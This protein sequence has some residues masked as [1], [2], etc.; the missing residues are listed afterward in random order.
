MLT[1]K[2]VYIYI[3]IYIYVLHVHQISYFVAK[4]SKPI[5]DMVTVGQLKTMS[6]PEVSNDTKDV[7][8]PITSSF[9]KTLGG[10]GDNSIVVVAN[11]TNMI[12]SVNHPTK[13][14]VDIKNYNATSKG[15]RRGSSFGW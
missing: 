5:S 3:C 12:E 4:I 1:N 2:I 14:D 10:E 15:S 11:D 13:E 9:T 7:V 6:A 8:D